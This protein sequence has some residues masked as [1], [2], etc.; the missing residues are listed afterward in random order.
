MS[1]SFVL[2]ALR[3][4]SLEE[5]LNL[6]QARKVKTNM[7][8]KAAG[9]DL[10]LWNDA[11]EKVTS[12]NEDNV[13]AFKKTNSYTQEILK[14]ETES[15][16]EEESSSTVSTT[17]FL[18]WQREL[19]KDTSTPSKKDAF[20][21]YGRATEMYVVKSATPEGKEKIRFASTRGVLVNKKQA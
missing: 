9:E 6:S 12:K 14:P 10:I 18:L 17:D 15:K 16:T 13:L 1:K 3:I 8:K 7:L 11:S 19:I 5:M 21:G 2:Q 20:K 4:F